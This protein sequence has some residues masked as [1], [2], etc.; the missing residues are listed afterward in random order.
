MATKSDKA[1]VKVA[2]VPSPGSKKISPVVA[3]L[4]STNSGSCVAVRSLSVTSKLYA[5]PDL[6]RIACVVGFIKADNVPSSIV[7]V[8]L[9]VVLASM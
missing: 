5:S 6:N 7:A 4:S 9:P 8:I 2:S 3:A 1:P